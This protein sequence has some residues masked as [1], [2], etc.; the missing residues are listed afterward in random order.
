VRETDKKKEKWR[1][2]N[3]YICLPTTYKVRTFLSLDWNVEQRMPSLCSKDFR[4]P[5]CHKKCRIEVFV[6]THTL[7]TK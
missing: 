6:L 7:S 5:A 1:E 4:I 3:I 2:E